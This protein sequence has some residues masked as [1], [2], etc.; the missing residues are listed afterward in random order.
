MLLGLFL[1][2]IPPLP[3]ELGPYAF[4]Q[5]LKVAFPAHKVVLTFHVK[6]GN[7]TDRLICVFLMMSH[8]NVL[9]SKVNK[10]RRV[11]IHT[12]LLQ[13]VPLTDVGMESVTDTPRLARITHK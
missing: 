1:S 5:L 8:P 7:A 12:R 11:L 9:N 3:R 2:A 4:P 10:S 6:Q 13:C